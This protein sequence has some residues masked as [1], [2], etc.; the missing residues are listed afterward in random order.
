M[1]VTPIPVVTVTPHPLFHLA[2]LLARL[3]AARRGACQRTPPLRLRVGGR[4]VA[5]ICPQLRRS[6][7]G[8]RRCP[9]RRPAP[10]YLGGVPASQACARSLEVAV[11]IEARKMEP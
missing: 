5:K 8:L 6:S 9:R 3:A 4:K 10:N 7:H 11:Q 1:S 2:C